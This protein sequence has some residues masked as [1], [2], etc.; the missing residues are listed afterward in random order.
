MFQFTR[1]PPHALFY[2]GVGDEVKPRRVSPFGNLRIV[3]SVQLPGAYRRLR[4]LHRQ[5]VPRHSSH[6]LCSLS[7]LSKQ[8]DARCLNLLNQYATFKELVRC[9]VGVH[10]VR[11]QEEMIPEVSTDVKPSMK[12]RLGFPL[13]SA[14]ASLKLPFRARSRRGASVAHYIQRRIP[15]GGSRRSDF[16][17]NR[18]RRP[19]VGIRPL[20]R[21]LR[22]APSLSVFRATRAVRAG[23]D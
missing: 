20:D 9:S 22:L 8:L 3:A 17:Q 7:I 11:R 21:S 14:L 15:L 4:V 10:S 19:S 23:H 1:C 12:N 18:S 5:F 16:F 2:S 13:S 6:T